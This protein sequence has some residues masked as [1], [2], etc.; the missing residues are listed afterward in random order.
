MLIRYRTNS[1]VP[2]VNDVNIWFE[3]QTVDKMLILYWSILINNE[4]LV[5]S[6]RRFNIYL[7]IGKTR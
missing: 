7:I 2:V 4:Y 6:F 3:A 1:D 5:F